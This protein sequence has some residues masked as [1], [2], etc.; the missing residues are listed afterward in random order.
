MD[1]YRALYRRFRP[2]RFG[3][4]LGQ[5]HVA[6]TLRN[7]VASGHIAHAFLFCGPRGTGKTS[8]AKIFAK[9]I[10]CQNPQEGEPCLECPTCTAGENNM[11]VV[12]IDAAS[13]NGVDEIRDLRDKV[14]FPPS[15]GRYKVYIIDEVHMLSP[16]A[17]NA[18]LK[19]LEEPPAH[20]VFILATTEAQRLPATIVSRCQRFDF[21]RIDVATMV[22]RLQDM[23]RE[24]EVK[25]S[26]EALALIARAAEGDMRDCLSLLDQSLAFSPDGVEE[27]DVVQLLGAADPAALSQMV[28]AMLHGDERGTITSLADLLSGGADLG[29]LIKELAEELRRLLLC[30]LLDK[31]EQL[32]VCDTQTV[33]RLRKEGM[34]IP[35]AAIMRAIELLLHCEAELRFAAQPRLIAEWTLLRICRASDEDSITALCERVARLE[36]ALQS[37]SFVPA[38]DVPSLPVQDAP[39]PPDEAPPQADEGA[40]PLPQE[41]PAVAETPSAPSAPAQPLGQDQVMEELSRRVKREKIALFSALQKGSFSGVEGNLFKLNFAPENEIFANM[42]EMEVNRKFIE[43]ILQELLGQEVRLQCKIVEEKKDPKRE[44]P[45]LKRLEELFGKDS[46]EIVED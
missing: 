3:Q 7:Q 44:N 37:G 2:A 39:P 29:F 41:E 36:E 21:R 32:L 1:H 10:N 38:G 35:Q 16:G 18:L 5:E 42:V 14:R 26:P 46:I 17:F 15:M 23:T 25:I 28:R 24:L 13:N 27:K 8:L 33:D 11:D 9:A 34:G 45:A 4:V 20:A 12:E 19:T 30:Q 6:R 31:P 40:L 43:G 22:G